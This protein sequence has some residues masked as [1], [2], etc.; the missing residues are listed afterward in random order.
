MRARKEAIRLRMEQ[1]SAARCSPGYA[2]DAHVGRAVIIAM[3]RRARTVWSSAARVLVACMTI[4]AGSVAGAESIAYRV[5]RDVTQVEYVARALGIIEA[6]G[7]FTDVRGMIVLDP[8]VAQGDIDFEIDARSIDSGWNLRDAFVRGEPMLDADRHPLIRFRSTRLVYRDGR[9]VAIEG[10]LTLRGVTQHVA[11]DVTRM[12]C[13]AADC[14]ARAQATIKRGDF[15]MES[16][17]P[18]VGDDVE[19]QF[20]VL[21]HRIPEAITGR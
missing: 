15:G 4:A 5:D 13:A 11:L 8:D 14:E 3:L 2:I 19:L 21:A 9:L 17:A 10:M 1:R 16:Y 7:R 18:F 20:I 12:A 6:R